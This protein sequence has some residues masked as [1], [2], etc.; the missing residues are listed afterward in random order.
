MSRE[1]PEGWQ[2]VTIGQV[3]DINPENLAANT[4]SDF[5]LKYIDVATVGGPSVMSEPRLIAF[6]EAPSRARKKVQQG[7]ILVST[8]RPYL[9]SFCKV[10]LRDSNLVASTAFAV[11]RS[12][13]NVDGDFLYQHVLGDSFVKHLTP[14]M[15]GSNYP[16]VTASDVEAYDFLL[17]PL[18][19][20]RRIAEILS[21][22]DEAIAA[23]RAVIEQTKKVRSELLASQFPLE[24]ELD[25]DS[26]TGSGHFNGWKIS[27]ASYVCT[28]IIDCKNRTP[29]LVERGYAVVRTPNVRNGRF[30]SAGLQFT[31]PDSFREWTARGLP[32]SGDVL[33]TREAPYG[34]VCLAPVMEFCLGQRM[35]FLRP[36]LNKITSAYLVYA[37]QSASVKKEM[38]RRAGGSTVGHLRVKD[39]RDLPIPVAPMEQQLV[40]AKM[41]GAL[42]QSVNE[43][44]GA[45]GGLETLKSA[46]MSDLLTGRKRVT[47]TLP[48]AAE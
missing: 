9:R 42:D 11:L 45:L 16:A 29:P 8:V 1:V 30:H 36:D 48:M 28:D 24:L 47:D 35:M 37:L 2:Q 34:E 41:L 17:P 26:T 5:L 31:D 19:E 44:S 38:F 27:P 22:V 12:K 25:Q 18:H 21:S 43:N 33:F 40:I 15:K 32:K 13:T 20:Q 4:A 14:R 46:L 3:A 39:V 7:D 6:A 23:T 10:S